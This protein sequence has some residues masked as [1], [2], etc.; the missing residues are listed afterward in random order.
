ML[1][2]I[3]QFL[4]SIWG[5]IYGWITD[6]KP[7]R[8]IR[9]MFGIIMMYSF[10]SYLYKSHKRAKSRTKEM[11]EQLIEEMYEKNEDGLY[12]WEIDTDTSAD[13]IPKD[14]SVYAD[15]GLVRPNRGRWKI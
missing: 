2:N 14:A 13:R 10:Y 4:Q 11:D 6:G 9:G 1:D 5:A 12:P 8:K 15:K 3:L 7:I